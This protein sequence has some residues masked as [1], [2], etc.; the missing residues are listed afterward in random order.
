MS[1]TRHFSVGC[2]I[3][4]L[5]LADS[6]SAWLEQVRKAFDAIPSVHNLKLI[7]INDLNYRWAGGEI[8]QFGDE[9]IPVPEIGTT[10]FDI[11]IP[12]R[13]QTNLG[14][15]LGDEEVEDFS[16]ITFF[17]HVHPVTFV[18]CCD[19]EV[20]V[21]NPSASMIIVREFLIT[22]LRKVQPEIELFQIGPSPFHVDFSISPGQGKTPIGGGF[23]Y[24]KEKIL[25]YDRVE[26]YY[27]PEGK[28]T[29]GTTDSA[30]WRL[31]LA[32]MQEFS[33]FYHFESLRNARL[34]AMG[35]LSRDSRELAERFKDKGIRAYLY[36]TF[37]LRHQLQ[38]A[39][40]ETI[41]ARLDAMRQKRSAK[42]DIDGLYSSA[43]GVGLKEYLE[44]T[45][46]EEYLDEI[47]A[48]EKILE[49]LEGRHS[50]EVQRFATISFSLLG[51]VVGA[52][53]TAA[54]RTWWG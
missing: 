50:Q 12:A 18:S 21:R 1:E 13:L 3:P 27:E 2:L 45:T 35:K 8:G 23:S 44:R 47:E 42:E 40:L 28:A 20:D 52:I 11:H 4:K 48:S 14:V 37:A 19:T 15:P 51:V 43:E 39:R 5:P 17:N 46:E 29:G 22:Q 10:A 9:E 16:V 33:Y 24:S 7:G 25:G 31:Y 41:S 30:L 36:R 6:P 34:R 38:S 54:F 53:L 26:Y 32:T 49:M